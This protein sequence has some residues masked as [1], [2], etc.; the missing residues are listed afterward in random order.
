MK[1]FSIPAGKFTKQLSLERDKKRLQKADLQASMKEK[2]RQQ[3]EQ[4]GDGQLSA[5]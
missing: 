3:A 4:Q 1:R 2:K 5:P